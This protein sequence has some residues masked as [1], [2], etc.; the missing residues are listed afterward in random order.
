LIIGF[1]EDDLSLSLALFSGEWMRLTLTLSY[2]S[3]K[4][5]KCYFPLCVSFCSTREHL[6]HLIIVSL[7]R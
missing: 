4:K 2:D 1:K 3:S 5:L 6:H 7:R